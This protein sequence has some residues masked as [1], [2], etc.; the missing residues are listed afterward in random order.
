M[1]IQLAQDRDV[2][3][4]NGSVDKLEELEQKRLYYNLIKRPFL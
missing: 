3:C 2:G 4:L 1:T